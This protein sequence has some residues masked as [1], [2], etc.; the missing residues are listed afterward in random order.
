MI[1]ISLCKITN[2]FIKTEWLMKSNTYISHS[3]EG[4]E[5][6]WVQYSQLPWGQV[7]HVQL[8][9]IYAATLRDV[10]SH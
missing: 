1:K 3:W 10:F 8:D 2:M 5:M 7:W 6:K 9:N 4:L